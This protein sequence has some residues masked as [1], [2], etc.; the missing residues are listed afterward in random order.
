MVQLSH[1][2]IPDSLQP[3]YD[4]APHCAP[5]RYVCTEV[6]LL[7]VASPKNIPT[8]AAAVLVIAAIGAICAHAPRLLALNVAQLTQPRPVCV[9]LPPMPSPAHYP[10]ELM[11]LRQ[12][13][14]WRSEARANDPTG[15][16]TKV[17]YQAT[18]YKASNT[19][20]EHWSRFDYALRTWQQQLVPCDGIGFVFSPGDPYAG[21][22]LDDLWLS[23]ADEGA[24]WGDEIIDRFRDTYME[25][26]PSGRGLKIWC[27][28]TLLGSGRNWKVGHGA[29]EIYDRS[30]F[31][32]VTGRAGP[33]HIITDH[34]SDVE[35]LIAYLD[36]G[37]R[38]YSQSLAT[39]DG[40]I[41]YGT[42]HNT[43][44]S[45]AG[46]MRRRGMTTEAI[47]AALQVVN[48]QQCER[49]GPPE[50]IHKIAM[51]AARWER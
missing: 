45:M 7:A 14:I 13:V 37:K 48:A 19:N 18:G 51:S 32:A 8:L 28:A 16:P 22:D 31:F 12:W 20:P 27:R 33:S 9:F 17:P 38:A 10:K 6:A 23:D 41:P 42:Q 47:E 25:E 49:P 3:V 15:K 39:V 26:S 43:L 30:R 24:P 50:N 29:I 40:K 2:T 34:Q 11:A 44:V 1:A 46:T 5:V 35:S 36:G 4:V 21:I